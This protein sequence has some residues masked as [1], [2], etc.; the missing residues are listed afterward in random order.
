M[1]KRLRIFY[2]HGEPEYS[3]PQVFSL[4]P[5]LTGTFQNA[6]LRRE[7]HLFRNSTRAPF[8][9]TDCSLINK[10]DLALRIS[11]RGADGSGVTFKEAQCL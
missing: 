10:S 2:L 5:L 7:R 1:N 11:L 6:L 8:L 3:P 9:P 4:R